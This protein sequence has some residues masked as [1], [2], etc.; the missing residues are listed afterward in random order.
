MG[1]YHL[2]FDLL[3]CMHSSSIVLA[4]SSR[5]CVPRRG[6]SSEG[7]E[8]QIGNLEE[9]TGEKRGGPSESKKQKKHRESKSDPKKRPK[10]LR[11]FADALLGTPWYQT[12]NGQSAA[13]SLQSA[14]HLGLFAGST[15]AQISGEARATSRTRRHVPTKRIQSFGG[16]W[17]SSSSHASRDSHTIMSSRR[18]STSSGSRPSVVRRLRRVRNAC[19]SACKDSICWSLLAISPSSARISSAIEVFMMAE[20]TKGGR[21][22][23]IPVPT[24]PPHTCLA[25]QGP[26]DETLQSPRRIFVP[27]KRTSITRT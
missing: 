21:H 13:R 2:M 9:Q 25:H 12:L 27:T 8:K 17:S 22:S 24:R 4:R 1:C 14:I 7:I 15:Y 23:H 10:S 6:G 20:R 16:R 19:A 11:G 26:T 18:P 5:R 3:Q